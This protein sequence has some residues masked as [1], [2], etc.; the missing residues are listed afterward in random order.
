MAELSLIFIYGTLRCGGRAH[1]LMD[2]AEF[3]GDGAIAGRL[4]HV[5][6]YP[7]L[8]HD[9]RKRVKGELYR[10]NQDQLK[11]L[12]R[13]EGCSESPPLYTRESVEVELENSE[14]LTA[15][16]YLFQQLQAHHEAIESGDWLEWFKHKKA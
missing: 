12:D 9:A 6:Q 2:G 8:I 13:Y 3:V 10:V 15:G 14:K 1:H 7:G 5:D 16:V 4:V 11:E